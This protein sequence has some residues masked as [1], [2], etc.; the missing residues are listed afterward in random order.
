MP[1]LDQQR[2]KSAQRTK[3]NGHAG[4]SAGWRKIGHQHTETIAIALGSHNPGIM[5]RCLFSVRRHQRPF[6]CGPNGI[7][8]RV[9]FYDFF[10]QF[11]LAVFLSVP[12]NRS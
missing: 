3:R 5:A 10:G 9:R 12:R 7:A 8:D 2:E 4:S 6:A 1:A 11:W